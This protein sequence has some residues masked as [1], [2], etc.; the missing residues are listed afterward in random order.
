MNAYQK[1]LNKLTNDPYTKGAYKG[2]APVGSRTKTHRRYIQ[3][4]SSV[5]AR[6]YNTEVFTLYPDGR[7]DLCTN[8]WHTRR[9]TRDFMSEVMPGVWRTIRY[10]DDSFFCIKT[11]DGWAQVQDYMRLQETDSGI[12]LLS[13]PQT[14][15]YKAVN[16]VATKA[17][18]KKLEPIFETAEMML[19]LGDPGPFPYH[20]LCEFH[21]DPDE[22]LERCEVMARALMFELDRYD[23]GQLGK[24]RAVFNEA[25][26]VYEGRYGPEFL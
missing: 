7:I 14:F 19:L 24:L 23:P 11:V 21:A 9:T 8:G 12:K 1:A 18:R 22:C 17:I 3:R 26:A 2:D 16:R 6:M 5:V 4:G 10:K 25:T 13:T 20:H 15:D